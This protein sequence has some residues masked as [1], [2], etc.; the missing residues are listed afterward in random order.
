MID[1]EQAIELMRLIAIRKNTYAE[2]VLG[3]CSGEESDKA[4]A[5]LTDYIELLTAKE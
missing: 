1:Q 2:F 4:A 3:L 5:A